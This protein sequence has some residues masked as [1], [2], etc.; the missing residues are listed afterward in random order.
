MGDLGHHIVEAFDVL[1]VDGG[2][3]VDAVGQQLLD[4]EITLGMAAAG[5]VGVGELVDQRDLRVARD[6]RV[7]I[8]FLERL[9]LVDGP[10]AR[11]DLEALQQRLR[12]HPAMG[13]D[14]TDHDIDARLQ[15]GV[16]VLQHLIGLADAGG[17]ADKDLEPAGLIVLAPGGFQQRVRRGSFIGVVALICHKAL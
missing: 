14:R 15:L 1:D 3:D 13:L 6:Q 2:I 11:D 17:G 8:H 12:L 4:V 7:E 16:G 9:I 10:L 5:D